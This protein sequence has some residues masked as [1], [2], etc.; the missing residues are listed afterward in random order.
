MNYLCRKEI[1]LFLSEVCRKQ[2]SFTLRKN[3]NFC[4]YCEKQKQ[5]AGHRDFNSVIS[6]VLNQL[7]LQ[8]KFIS[9]DK[10]PSFFNISFHLYSAQLIFWSFKS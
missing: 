4:S 1:L 5:K 9:R 6:E 7:R 8:K 2:Q 3:R 10:F